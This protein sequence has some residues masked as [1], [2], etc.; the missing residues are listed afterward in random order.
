MFE[1]SHPA[2]YHMLSYNSVTCSSQK[3]SK[4][5]HHVL[6]VYKGTDGP[7]SISRYLASIMSTPIE[8]TTGKRGK[9]NV[10]ADGFRYSLDKRRTTATGVVNSYWRCVTPG[11]SCRLVLHDDAISNSPSTMSANRVQRSR[12]TERKNF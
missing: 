6:R 12:C 5:S 9:E 3:C 7:H 11:C 4:S 10:I 2:C 1:R 8:F